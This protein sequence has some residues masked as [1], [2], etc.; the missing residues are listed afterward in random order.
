MKVHNIH[1]QMVQLAEEIGWPEMYRDDLYR[2]DLQALRKIDL[3]K[4]FVWV[5]RQSGT[6]LV[7]IKNTSDVLD[8]SSI[9]KVFGYSNPKWYAWDG[10]SF[11]EA[12]YQNVYMWAMRYVSRCEIKREILCY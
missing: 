10:E 4:P 9:N 2:H 6:H 8:L 1:D 12:P 11:Y 7:P 5:L 3:D